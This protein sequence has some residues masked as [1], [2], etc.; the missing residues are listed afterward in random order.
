VFTI[1]SNLDLSRSRR[2]SVNGIDHVVKKVVLIV[3]GV[4]HGSRGPLLYPAQEIRNSAPTWD[5]VP[6]TLEHPTRPAREVPHQVVGVIRRPR[7]V[8]NQ[9]VAEG[10]F[11]LAK[12]W[13][14]SA[15][16]GARLESDTA[17]EVSTGLGLDRHTSNGMFAGRRYEAI[18]KNYR[19]DHL[20]VLLNSP[21]AC[22]LADGCG[23][24]NAAGVSPVSLKDRTMC[25]QDDEYDFTSPA[26][27][28]NHGSV[29]PAFERREVPQEIVNQMEPDVID[30]VSL[31]NARQTG[32]AITNAKP[33]DNR[34]PSAADAMRLMTDEPD[35]GYASLSA[36]R[37]TNG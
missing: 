3:E 36:A 5:G 33:V 11:N 34:Q 21:G 25:G 31:S 20:A 32:G 1:I 24:L 29:H 17:I 28:Q 2:E 22:S 30:Y 10:W 37:Q 19:P 18:A 15:T 8:G 27:Y 35:M 16:L 9:L 7:F 13:I 12:A 6:I 14:T 4:L 23:I 26:P